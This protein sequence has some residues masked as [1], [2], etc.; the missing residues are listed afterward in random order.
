ME[1]FS[2]YE[3]KARFSEVLRRVREGKSVL[4]SYHGKNVAEIRPVAETSSFQERLSRLTE[5]G[6][7]HPPA[8]P[9]APLQPLARRPGALA[10][11][12]EDRD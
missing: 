4:I 3:A 8:N 5:E 9:E 6:V 10:R 2:T 1:T 11:F 7:L 12:L